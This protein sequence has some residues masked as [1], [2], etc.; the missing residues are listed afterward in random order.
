[1]EA[2]KAHFAH[3]RLHMVGCGG[4]LLILVIGSVA[5]LTLLAIAGAVICGAFCLDMIRMMMTMR[6]RRS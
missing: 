6:P 2:V 4:G 5:N 3:H 1:M